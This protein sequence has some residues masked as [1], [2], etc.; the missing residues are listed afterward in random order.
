MNS[1][2]HI[3][4]KIL[5]ALIW[6]T[7]LIHAQAAF[8][9]GV[10]DRPSPRGH[11]IANLL[12][13]HDYPFALYP[14]EATYLLFTNTSDLNREAIA[15]YPWADGGKEKE[16]QFQISTAIPVYRGLAGDNSVL[17]I[18]YTQR[19]WWQV[20]SPEI[21]SPFRETNYE[22]QLFLGWATDY[23]IAGWSVQEIEAGLNH[24]SNGQADPTSRSWNRVY[25]RMLAQKGDWQVELKPWFLLGR[26]SDNNADITDYLGYYRL[27]VGYR[28]GNSLFT[29]Q[30]H[31]NWNTGYGGAQLSWSYPVSQH[32]RFYTQ[33]FS[34]YGESLIDYDHHQTRFAMGFTLNEPF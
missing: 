6:I 7:G 19:S 26:P 29:L 30:G 33:C 20:F 2:I 23:P 18:S 17:A 25:A 21:S 15:T 27:K 10:Q 24:Q 1:T 12:E 32:V 9:N 3:L 31:Y 28:P 14:Y 8:G 22:P 4:W 11:V 5:A 34:G 13:E 16:V